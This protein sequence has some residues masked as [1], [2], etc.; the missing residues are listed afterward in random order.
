MDLWCGGRLGPPCKVNLLLEPRRYYIWS[1][2][3]PDI[4]WTAALHRQS[5]IH[6]GCLLA[7][8]HLVFPDE[9]RGLVVTFL[10][11]ASMPCLW[12][13]VFSFSKFL[14]QQRWL[15]SLWAK[16]IWQNRHGFFRNLETSCLAIYRFYFVYLSLETMATSSLITEE[17]FSLT[18]LPS[19]FLGMSGGSPREA[20]SSPQMCL[21]LCVRNNGESRTV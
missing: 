4:R 17:G 20:E 18:P 2:S 8:L 10:N 3:P 5:R 21:S 14:V 13:P 6:E 11:I 15:C 16:E 1:S 9:T 19:H 7:F 12:T